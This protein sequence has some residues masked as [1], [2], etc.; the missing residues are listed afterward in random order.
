MDRGATGGG[1][2]L[3]V[4]V[5]VVALAGYVLPATGDA[6]ATSLDVAAVAGVTTAFVGMATLAA[7]SRDDGDE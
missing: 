2:T 7:A 5:V 1:L 3:L 4:G 6:G